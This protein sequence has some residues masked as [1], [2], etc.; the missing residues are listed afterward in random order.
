[1]YDNEK[2]MNSGRSEVRE[3]DTLIPCNKRLKIFTYSTYHIFYPHA[4]ACSVRSSNLSDDPLT[5]STQ[6]SM[7]KKTS[8]VMDG[9][10]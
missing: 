5:H 2:S 9:R 7:K 3:I 1:M 4:D 6:T 10:G 8:P